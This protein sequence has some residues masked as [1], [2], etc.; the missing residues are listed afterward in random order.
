MCPKGGVTVCTQGQ[1]GR[2]HCS[3]V[4]TSEDIFALYAQCRAE[5]VSLD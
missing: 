4:S 1:V 2:G 5:S 3:I